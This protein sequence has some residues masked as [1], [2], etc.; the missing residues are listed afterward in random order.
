MA[1][2][3]SSFLLIGSAQKIMRKPVVWVEPNAITQLANKRSVEINDFTQYTHETSDKSS[4]RLR[5]C[6]CSWVY[7]RVIP[8]SDANYNVQ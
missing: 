6:S 1:L 8:I 7:Q 3:Q 2:R 5:Q 4:R